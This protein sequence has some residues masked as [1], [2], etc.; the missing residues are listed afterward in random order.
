M[1]YI[2]SYLPATAVLFAAGTLTLVGFVALIIAYVGRYFVPW[3]TWI[4][5]G[6]LVALAFGLWSGGVGSA[7]LVSEERQLRRD[8]QIL[9][10]RVETQKNIIEADAKRA[11]NAA[12]RIERLER[13]IVTDTPKNDT[14]ALPRDVLERLR[15]FRNRN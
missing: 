13:S 3:R 8:N 1:A 4:F 15:Q 5:V 12:D 14:R 10:E 2:W 9:T 7:Q 11:Q 6:G